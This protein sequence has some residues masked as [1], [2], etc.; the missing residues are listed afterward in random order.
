[1][2]LVAA[3]PVLASRSA[4]LPKISAQTAKTVGAAWPPEPASAKTSQ[5]LLEGRVATQATKPKR[6]TA[7]PG[8]PGRHLTVH[9]R[10]GEP[11]GE[12]TEAVD[13]PVRQHVRVAHPVEQPETATERPTAHPASR[14]GGQ[15]QATAAYPAAAAAAA[16]SSRQGI[17]WPLEAPAV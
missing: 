9:K 10:C 12:A 13:V 3:H 16:P 11:I 15:R 6:V 7:Q 17:R 8:E 14:T 4:V 2:M 5:A 1:M